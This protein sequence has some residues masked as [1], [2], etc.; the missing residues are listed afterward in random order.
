MACFHSLAASQAQKVSLLAHSHD[1]SFLS[2]LYVMLLHQHDTA[3]SLGCAGHLTTW[4]EC[5]TFLDIGS[6][7][8]IWNV[9]MRWWIWKVGIV[10]SSSFNVPCIVPVCRDTLFTHYLFLYL[11]YFI[12]NFILIWHGMELHKQVCHFPYH[13]HVPLQ[14]SW[15]PRDAHAGS[16]HV[17]CSKHMFHG[18]HP[19]QPNNQPYWMP[20]WTVHQD[21]QNGQQQAVDCLLHQSPWNQPKP[22]IRDQW[23]A[24]FTRH[25][26]YSI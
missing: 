5:T 8:R 15:K 21:G 3:G 25:N 18:F 1:I 10:C 23:H 16:A 19:I 7:V 2:Q 22:P 14:K 20:P 4:E 24:Q 6:L 9:N 17:R 12:L 11:F 26:L 13:L